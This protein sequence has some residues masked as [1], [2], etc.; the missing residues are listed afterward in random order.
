MTAVA[1]HMPAVAG[2]V[3][4][5]LGGPHHDIIVGDAVKHLEKCKKEGKLFDFI[6]GDLTDIQHCSG[7]LHGVGRVLTWHLFH[8]TVPSGLQEVEGITSR[9]PNDRDPYVG[10]PTRES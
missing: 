6:F 3:L 9:A 8:S 4:D 2:G 7:S 1:R 10:I 5:S